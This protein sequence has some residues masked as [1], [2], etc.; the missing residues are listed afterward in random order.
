MRGALRPGRGRARARRG[1]CADEPRRPPLPA[2]A[3]AP[4]LRSEE[5]RERER[6]VHQAERIFNDLWRTVPGKNGKSAAGLDDERRRALLEL[7]QENILYFLEKTAPRLQP[8]QRE[9]L[10]IVRLIAQYFYPQRQTKVMN[11]G[12]ATYCHYRIMTAAARARPDRRRR[13]PGIPALPHQRRLPAGLRRSGA[14]RGINP[15]ALGFAHDAGHRAH[16]HGPDRGGPRVVPR[17][18]R[19]RATPWPRLRDIWAELPRRELRR[20]S[21][22]ARS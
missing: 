19:L 18:R 10:R 2:Q 7:P 15:Y 11:E 12:C 13:V 6:R 9:I 17:H 20:R 5:R 8:W 4:D 22:S 14:I 21:S 3:Q 16:L 1:A